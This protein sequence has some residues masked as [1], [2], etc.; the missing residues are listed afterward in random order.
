MVGHRP[1]FPRS[2]WGRAR[3]VLG[4]IDPTLGNAGK[5]Q[6]D[7]DFGMRNRCALQ[8]EPAGLHRRGIAAVR[9]WPLPEIVGYSWNVG[10]G[11]RCPDVLIWRSIKKQG[12]TKGPAQRQ[13]AAG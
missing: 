6:R 13:E 8:N 7:T 1:C 4:R 12:G 5:G 2:V 9:E 11:R 10:W 3:P